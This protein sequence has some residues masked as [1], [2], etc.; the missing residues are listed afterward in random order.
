MPHSEHLTALTDGQTLYSHCLPTAVQYITKLVVLFKLISDSKFEILLLCLFRQDNKI[1]TT[2]IH[3][4]NL[5]IFIH[6]FCI[7]SPSAKIVCCNILNAISLN[8]YHCCCIMTQRPN[9]DH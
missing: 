2:V 5:Q 1:N 8:C 7:L 9:G 3:T 6:L 4:L